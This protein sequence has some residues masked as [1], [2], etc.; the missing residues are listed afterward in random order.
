LTQLIRYG[1][2][3]ARDVVFVLCLLLLV[4]AAIMT[5]IY[6]FYPLPRVTFCSPS[7]LLILATLGTFLALVGLASLLALLTGRLELRDI[8]PECL[9]GR[10]PFG[11]MIFGGGGGVFGLVFLVLLMA[12]GAMAGVVFAIRLGKKI[13]QRHWLVR[14]QLEEVRRLVVIDLANK[15]VFGE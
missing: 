6:L 11:G 4:L 9:N 2:L 10:R 12:L 1:A 7:S 15:D 8:L 3:V 13:A 14:W 5:A